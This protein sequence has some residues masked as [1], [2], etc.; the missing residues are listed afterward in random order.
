M[1]LGWPSAFSVRLGSLTMDLDKV[2]ASIHWPH[3]KNV[4][5]LHIFLGMTG[6]YRK[7]I[8]DYQGKGFMWGKEQHRSFDKLKVA[9]ATAPY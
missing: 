3:P 5:E 1:D 4:E 2:E 9:L 6:F 8:K 7:F